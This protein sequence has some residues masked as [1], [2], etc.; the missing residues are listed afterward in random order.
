VSTDGG[1][2]GGAGAARFA[3]TSPYA[4]DAIAAIVLDGVGGSGS[5]RL[6]LAGDEP[7]SPAPALV[8]TAL[9]RLREQTGT[10][11]AL[12]SVPT[13]MV[14]PPDARRRARSLRPWSTLPPRTHLAPESSSDAGDPGTR[15]PASPLA[16]CGAS[17]LA[18]RNCRSI[19]D[20]CTPSAATVCRFGRRSA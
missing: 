11:P 18:R 8:S 19:P 20:L 3:A 14:G 6:A 16:L 2:Y 4:K 9:A 10:V 15:L 17:P 5:P 12:P 7:R 13:R 1:A